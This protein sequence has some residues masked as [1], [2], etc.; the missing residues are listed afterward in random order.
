MTPATCSAGDRW[1]FAQI[2]KRARA[3][4]SG[5]WQKMQ[6]WF[7]G[8][9]LEWRYQNGWLIMNNPIKIGMIW[10]YPYFTK[11]PHGARHI[12]TLWVVVKTQGVLHSALVR[13]FEINTPATKWP[14]QKCALNR[15]TEFI[16]FMAMF[17]QPTVTWQ[18]KIHGKSVILSRLLFYSWSYPKNHS[19]LSF[20]GYG[21]WPCSLSLWHVAILTKALC[22]CCNMC[23]NSSKI[24]MTKS[25]HFGTCPKQWA[26]GVSGTLKRLFEY[27]TWLYQF[28]F[29][30]HTRVKKVQMWHVSCQ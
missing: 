14:I 30:V 3:K 26:Q 1:D 2:R 22:L 19:C 23:G 15:D 21:H 20:S 11:P 29:S 28:W 18:G 27:V 16:S 4:S 8:G 6:C 13:R 7:P 24:P 12:S 10:G 9:F 17:N 5:P 25:R